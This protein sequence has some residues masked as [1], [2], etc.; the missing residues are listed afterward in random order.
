[1]FVVL[2]DFVIALFCRVHHSTVKLVHFIL[3]IN[4]VT[5]VFSQQ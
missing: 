5:T 1:M 4:I 3:C 2:L